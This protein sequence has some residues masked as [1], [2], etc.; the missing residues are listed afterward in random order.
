MVPISERGE[1]AAEL[2]VPGHWEGDLIIGKNGTS[3][4]AT[5]VERMSG[6]TGLL[7]LP[8]K[9]AEATTDGGSSTSTPCPR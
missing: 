9:N 4:T 1:D 7:A 6:F 3:C 5:L 8:P 2:R